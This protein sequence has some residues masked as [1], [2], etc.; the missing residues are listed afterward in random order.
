[1]KKQNLNYGFTLV[2]VLVSIT[3]FSIMFIS[4]IWI[5]IISTDIS[6][7][8]DINRVMQENLKNLASKI[9]EDIRKDGIKGVS[10]STID[11]C[12]FDK[13]TLKN[14]KVGDKLCAKS[15][16]IYYLAKKDLVLGEY[17]RVSDSLECSGLTD[18]CV[19]AMGPNEP[20]TNSYVS[21]KELKFYISDDSVPKV[22]INIVLQPSI[23]KGV[24]P[25]MIKDSKIIFQTTI[26]ERLF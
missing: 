5:Y 23:K 6:M 22:T 19:I 3:I 2:E 26:S 11:T 12:D 18:N 14:Y 1:M 15:G 20:L 16:N 8:S 4:I 7:K 9:S 24:K 13:T 25:D 21:I 17:Y 10:S